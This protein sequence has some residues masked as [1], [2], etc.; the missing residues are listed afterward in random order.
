[1]NKSTKSIQIKGFPLIKFQCYKKIQQ[2]QEGTLYM[3][4]L[5]WYR[6]YERAKGDDVVGD[7]FEALLHVNESK[8]IIPELGE[9]IEIKDGLIPTIHSNDFSFCMIGINPNSTNFRFSEIQKIEINKFGDAA[10]LITDT[11][12][13]FRRI[14]DAAQK[15]GFKVYCGFVQYYDKNIN[16]VNLLASLING[17]ENIAFWKR[18][19][20]S[21]QNEYRF[22]FHKDKASEDHIELDIGNIKNIS[23]II[24]TSSI[25]EKELHREL[26]E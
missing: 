3:K 26:K 19:K 21:Y 2:L 22:L 17:M 13:F 8:L 7:L 18:D 6:E 5:E 20:Y 25:L 10:L 15:S 23:K 14:S 16:S 24:K 11:D 4:N 9:E 1:M 12:E